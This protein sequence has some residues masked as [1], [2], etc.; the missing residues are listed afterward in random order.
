MT[1]KQDPEW[2]GLDVYEL[3]DGSFTGILDRKQNAK[4]VRRE[5]EKVVANM[6]EEERWMVREKGRIALMNK[7]KKKEKRQQ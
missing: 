3:P 1:P 7:N 5:G 6:L 2:S 4:A